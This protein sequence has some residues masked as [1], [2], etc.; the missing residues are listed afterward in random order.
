MTS[1]AEKKEGILVVGFTTDAVTESDI[2]SIKAA[3]AEALSDGIAR[4]VFRVE[5]GSLAN[6]LVISRLLLQCSEIVRSKKARLHFVE[7][8][9]QDKSV[10]QTVCESL[11]VLHCDNEE[12]L[13]AQFSAAGEARS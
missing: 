4:I 1:T 13:A 8:S 2:T 5:V 9:H 6:Q 10:F 3:V 12:K 7:E 11:H